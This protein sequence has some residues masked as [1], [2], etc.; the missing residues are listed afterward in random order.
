M[1]YCL[2]YEYLNDENHIYKSID[3]D[4][5]HSL[6]NGFGTGLVLIGGPW[7]ANC[8]A[9]IKEL[10]DVCKKNGL[11]VIY[12]YDPRFINI[13]NEVEDLRDCKSLEIKLK[14][15]EIVEKL[16]FKS[17][18]LVV[19]TLI[20]RMH[21][22]FIFGLRNGSCVGYYSPNYIKDKDGIHVEGETEDKTIDFV[23]EV[24]ALINK[25]SDNDK[26]FI[27]KLVEA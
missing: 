19:D 2:E 4:Y 9:I 10:N 12:N 11:D 23:C 3:Y 15:Y 16:K 14:Y 26:N 25:I 20:P 1:D 5:L 8:Q 7:C 27:F 18:E 17:N 22:P 6:L 13:F 21:V 24:T